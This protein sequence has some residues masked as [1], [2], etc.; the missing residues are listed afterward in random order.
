MTALQDG[1][2]RTRESLAGPGRFARAVTVRILNLS[3]AGEG[4]R[5][6]QRGRRRG[7]I[8]GEA[9]RGDRAP[10]ARDP[11]HGQRGQRDRIRTRGRTGRPRGGWRRRHRGP[12]RA[13]GRRAGHP[14][15]HS[16]SRHRQ[17][18]R[19]ESRNRRPDRRADRGLGAWPDRGD[20]SRRRARRVGR[21]TL[22]RRRGCRTDSR[23]DRIDGARAERASPE[24]C[25]GRTRRTRL[26]RR[27]VTPE[28]AAFDGEGGRSLRSRENS[29]SSRP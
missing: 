11:S 9:P 16:S 26:P 4:L 17:Q 24:G 14:A 19:Q 5:P 3:C 6:V 18:R 7:R 12:E 1:R 28:A 25:A 21:D 23:R 10:R 20:R 15:G 27:A 2:H 8:E 22:H 29:C 13:C